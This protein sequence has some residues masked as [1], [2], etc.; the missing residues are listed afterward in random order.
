MRKAQHLS[1]VTQI[2]P[3][4]S[5]KPLLGVHYTSAHLGSALSLYASL[6]SLL[7]LSAST[8]SWVSALPYRLPG[9]GSAPALSKPH[10]LLHAFMP[11]TTKFPLASPCLLSWVSSLQRCSPI[12]STASGIL[13]VFCLQLSGE[14]RTNQKLT[15][16]QMEQT[17]IQMSL[18]IAEIWLRNIFNRVA[19]KWKKKK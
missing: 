1:H 8:L 2:T 12:S 18:S 5:Q 19:E 7:A 13:R 15:W 9:V 11:Q 4:L 14:W 10:K 3:L 17:K 16:L 6:E